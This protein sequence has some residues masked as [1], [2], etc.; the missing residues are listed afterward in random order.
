MR[1]LVAMPLRT[2][3]AAALVAVSWAGSWALLC[4]VLPAT[5]VAAQAGA[6][7]ASFIIRIGS[8]TLAVERYVRT[9]DRLVAE[10]VQRSPSTMLHRLEMSLSPAGGV[11]RTEWTIR[12]PG[13]AEPTLHRVITFQ[14]DSAVVETTQGGTTRAQRVRAPGAIPVI[15]PFYS[16]YELAFRRLG[17][18]AT[19]TV[20][21]LG[22]AATVDIPLARAA[23][24]TITLTNQFGEPMRA[25]VDAAGN[26]RRLSTPAFTTVERTGWLDLDA[27][28]R[29]FAERDATGRGLGPLS[30]RHAY[31]ARVGDANLW[32]DYSRPSAR[33]RP[34]WGGLVPWDAVWRMGADM[35][36]HF[37]TDRRLQVG[38]LTLEPGT[39]TLFLLPAEAG[40]SLIVNRATGIGGLDH[41]PAQDVGRTALEVRPAAEPAEQFTIVVPSSADGARLEV[42]WADRIG[43]AP[44]RVLP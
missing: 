10:A 18:D 12:Q 15:N 14:G 38:E 26:L 1:N 22:G 9:A 25:T 23:G 13:A 24:D 2:L 37:A 30:P 28:A 34:I 16:P 17:G 33:G 43:S 20:T 5:P 31:R 44:L 8:D 42:R 32:V 40:W 11:T 6:D 35:A 36:A 39:Y 41:D 21:L 19:A 29:E 4:A 27:V 3:P 7:S